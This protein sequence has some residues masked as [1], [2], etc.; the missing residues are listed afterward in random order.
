MNTTLYTL[1]DRNIQGVLLRPLNV[2]MAASLNRLQFSALLPIVCH[3]KRETGKLLLKLLKLSKPPRHLS[4]DCYQ[5]FDF[6]Q[7]IWFG[8]VTKL[9]CG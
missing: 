3:K 8:G 6:F 1:T 5:S 9:R 2:Y 4:R 7:F